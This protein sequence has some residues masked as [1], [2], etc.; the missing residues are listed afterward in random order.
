M[1]L[2]FLTAF[3]FIGKLAKAALGV[4]R[5][6]PW[7]AAVI[8]LL[9]ACAWM[10]TGWNGTAADL[11]DCKDARAADRAAYEQ[12]QREAAEKARA[13]R[14]AKEAQYREQAERTDREHEQELA[15]ANARAERY[16]A[17]NRV[18][19]Q[20][21]GGASGGTGAGPEGGSASSSNGP[22]QDPLMVAVTEDDV[23]IC[24]ENT[25]RLQSVREWA[26]GL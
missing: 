5:K 17:G 8:A 1:P 16:I 18:R 6:H 12:A 13:A 15:D 10:W 14:L 2:F 11:Q 23:R 4:A 9:L 20:I 7:Q 19:P 22:G 25:T 3:G 24:T 21:A 26:L